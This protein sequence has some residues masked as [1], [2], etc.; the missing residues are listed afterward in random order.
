MLLAAT[1]KAASDLSSLAVTI[2]IIVAAIGLSGVG[3]TAYQKHRNDRRTQWWSR[4]EWALNALER[5]RAMRRIGFAMLDHLADEEGVSTADE[6]LIEQI[7]L[8]TLEPYDTETQSSEQEDTDTGSQTP[9]GS[10]TQP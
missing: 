3:V 4:V 6:R 7:V 10:E 8:A 9:R 2:P 1:A 5:K